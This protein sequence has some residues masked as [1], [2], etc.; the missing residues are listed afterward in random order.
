[1]TNTFFC[2]AIH[3]LIKNSST[4]FVARADVNNCSHLCETIATVTIVLKT[5]SS[6]VEQISEKVSIWIVSHET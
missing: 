5:F 4:A 3:G 2:V 6:V 1:M